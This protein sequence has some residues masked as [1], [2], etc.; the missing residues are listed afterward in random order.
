MSIKC[1][2]Y[3]CIPPKR[4]G[5]CHST[6]NEFIEWQKK[7]REE[8]AVIQNAKRKTSLINNDVRYRHSKMTGTKLKAR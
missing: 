5:Y 1:P 8:R 6:C 4:N 2:C 7:D 3:G